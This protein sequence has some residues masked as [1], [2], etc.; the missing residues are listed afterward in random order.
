MTRKKDPSQKGAESSPSA[1]SS[2][3]AKKYSFGSLKKLLFAPLLASTPG[4]KGPSSDG[5]PDSDIGWDQSDPFFHRPE[6][7]FT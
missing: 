6:V 4:T 7:A 1:K 3:S 2:K 5:S